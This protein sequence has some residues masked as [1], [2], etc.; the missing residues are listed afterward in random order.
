MFGN[1][2]GVESIRQ[3]EKGEEIFEDYEYDMSYEDTPRWYREA[4]NEF[5]SQ[6]KS[7]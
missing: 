5:H 2:R 1:I 7:G 4:F 3:I 6:K